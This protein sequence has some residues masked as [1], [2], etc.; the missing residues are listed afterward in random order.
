MVFNDSAVCKVPVSEVMK[1]V[2]DPQFRYGEPWFY[3][4]ERAMRCELGIGDDTEIYIRNENDRA[5]A[6]YA[7]LFP[8]MPDAFFLTI[9][10][11][12]WMPM[13]S[14]ALCVPSFQKNEKS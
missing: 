8:Q 11:A 13:I 5:K 4:N 1:A 2:L 7:I 9:S 10:C 14:V 6:I 3:Q 12:I